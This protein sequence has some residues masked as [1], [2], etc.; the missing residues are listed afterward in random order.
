MNT[1][2]FD[3]YLS[4]VL[5]ILSRFL[6]SGSSIDKTKWSI[7]KYV[8]LCICLYD[9]IFLHLVHHNIQRCNIIVLFALFIRILNLLATA[10]LKPL[11]IV[12]KFSASIKRVPYTN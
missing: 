5:Y 4:K 3:R 11:F 2:P 10:H 12:L 7:V 6:D 9:I 1:K 8:Y